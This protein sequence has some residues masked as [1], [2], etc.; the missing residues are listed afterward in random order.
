MGALL[1]LESVNKSYWRGDVE[2]KVLT[3]VSL[4][5]GAGELVAIWGKRGAGKTTLLKV[6]ARLEVPD[7]GV[8]RFDGVDLANLSESAHARL[9]LER[10]GWVRRTPPGIDLRMLDYV[11][12]PLL[13]KQGH[14]RAYAR[15]RD[16]LARVGASDCAGQRWGSLCDGERALIGV[17]HGIVRRPELVLVDDPTGNLDV[18]ERER[19]TQLLR[20]LADDE[21][22]AVVMAVP[23][24][25]AV[26]RAHHIASLGG[27]RLS[28]TVLGHG[29]DGAPGNVIPLRGSER[30][31]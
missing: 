30:S 22:V 18:L 5:V 7:H 29:R 25:P 28:N 1:T 12:L 13:A 11:A 3:D 20:S 14:R 21:G 23:D 16:A 17:A 24:M 31:A 4:A 19:I 26:M 2:V 9:M 8:V 15:A 10:I 27:G 6:A